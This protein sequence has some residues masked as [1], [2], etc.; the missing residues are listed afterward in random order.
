MHRRLP[1]VG[2][3]DYCGN[4]G[5]NR[6]GMG[7]FTRKVNMFHIWTI[8]WSCPRVSMEFLVLTLVLVGSSLHGQ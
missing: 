5:F 7:F 1:L 2:K 6:E 3:M 4:F 8:R